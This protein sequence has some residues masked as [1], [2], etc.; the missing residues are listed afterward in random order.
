MPGWSDVTL[1]NGS[2]VKLYMQAF[3]QE[4]GPSCVATIGQMFGRS[5]DISLA[6]TMVGA[7]DH[8][9]PP[10]G[11]DWN[12]DWAYMTSLTQALSRYGV[13]M[14][15]TKKRLSA[16][17]YKTFCQGRST[18]S[19]AILRVEWPDQSGHFVVTVGRNGTALQTFI[20]ILDP[21]Y[22]YQQVIL[23][24]DFP[25]YYPQSGVHGVLDA[26]WSVETT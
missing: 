17:A 20:E 13:K 7:V 15:Y 10:G 12:L 11:K 18:K 19:P 4:C 25:N 26:N 16:T 21:F 9:S 1:A 22:G 14:A 5:I 3:A 23:T 6:R 2:K 24:P 8:N